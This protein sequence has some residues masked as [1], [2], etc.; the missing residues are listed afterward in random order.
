M[1]GLARR[2]LR[3]SAIVAFLLPIVVRG[4]VI[5][6]ISLGCALNEAAEGCNVPRSGWMY[7]GTLEIIATP[8]AIAAVLWIASVIVGKRIEESKRFDPFDTL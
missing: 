8:W 1:L 5:L 4:Y 3:I 2:L 7:S 6:A